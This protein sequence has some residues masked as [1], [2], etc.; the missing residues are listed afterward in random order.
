MSKGKAYFESFVGDDGSFLVRVYGRGEFT[1]GKILA[2]VRGQAKDHAEGIKKAY[3]IGTKEVE[4]V[5]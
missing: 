4:G 1:N 3:D 2:E 5:Q